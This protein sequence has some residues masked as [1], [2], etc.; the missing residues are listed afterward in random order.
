MFNALTARSRFIRLLTAQPMTRR[1]CRSRTT[2]RDNH[3][4]ASRDTADVS[5][6]LLV[7]AICREVTVQQVRG[8]VEGVIAVGRHLLSL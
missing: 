2:A 4:V 7:R 8:D 3:P 1:E 6:P 5:S